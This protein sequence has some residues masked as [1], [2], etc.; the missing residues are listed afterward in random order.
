MKQ[1]LVARLRARTVPK[2][3]S[4]NGSNGHMRMEGHKPDPD[5]QEAAAEI[6]RLRTIAALAIAIASAGFGPASANVSGFP[7]WPVGAVV[8]AVSAA[9]V[10][11]SA[12][13][14]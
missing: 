12:I 9:A 10:R 4:Y 8:Q 13:F 7:P 11:M 3:V 14:M 1:D 2:F 5:A 6:E